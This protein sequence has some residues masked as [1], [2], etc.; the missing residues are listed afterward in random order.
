MLRAA[1]RPLADSMLIYVT[2]TNIAL[3]L[4]VL[5]AAAALPLLLRRAPRPLSKRAIRCIRP[6]L[7]LGPMASRRVDTRGMDRNAITAL[8]GSRIPRTNVRPASNDWRA[9][10]FTSGYETEDL[11]RYAGAARGFN[12]VMISL[13][14]TAAQYLS[15][16]GAH[17][18]PMPILAPPPR[19]RRALPETSPASPP[20]IP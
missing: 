16:Y 17:S 13:E 10:P 15:S 8:V 5:P 12:V 7:I 3:V 19:P 2:A 9:S 4:S 1:P 20:A 14:S 18:D 11:S 6:V